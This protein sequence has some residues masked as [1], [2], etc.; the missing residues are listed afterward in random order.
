[1]SISVWIST[2][3]AIATCAA[4]GAAVWGL[5]Y[6]RGLIDVG[7][8]DRQV[9]RA[10]ALHKEVTTGEIAAARNR[11]NELMY[12]AGEEAFGPRMCWR[13]TW[14]SLIPP[15]PAVAQDLGSRRFL[16]AYPKDMVS[17]EGHRPIHDLRLVLW[18]YD[19]I[20]EARKR[21]TSLDED[22]LV[23]LLG[24]QVVFWSLQCGRLDTKSGA[25]VRALI[26]LASWMEDKGWREDLRNVYR[27]TPEESFPCTEDDVPLPR[28][29]TSV[30][31]GEAQSSRPRRP[32]REMNR[33]ISASASKRDRQP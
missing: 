13:P 10:L 31:G 22:L 25:H 16:G 19:R 28:I 14:E 7:V 27:K 12:R 29:S 23:S 30:A 8:K 18:S 26:E 32:R 21:E 9:D 6:A 5:R 4:A 24:H 1:M 2:V 33:E 11:F 20:N 17:G 3:A 15:N